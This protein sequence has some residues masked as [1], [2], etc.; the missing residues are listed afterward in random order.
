MA[1]SQSEGVIEGRAVTKL[2]GA[3]VEQYARAVLVRWSGAE[4]GPH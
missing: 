4:C 2:M 3:F 1:E